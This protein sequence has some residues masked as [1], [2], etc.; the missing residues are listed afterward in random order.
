K[1]LRLATCVQ[2]LEHVQRDAKV[3]VPVLDNRDLRADL[4]V[5][6]KLLADLPAQTLAERLPGVT[7][8]AGE[9]PQAAEHG[10]Q[11]ALR[12]QDMPVPVADH[13]CGHIVVRRARLLRPDRAL[14]LH[15]KRP[16]LA[17]ISDR[18][19]VAARRARHAHP[20]P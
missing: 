17:E 7:L 9:L 10:V 14:L 18:A 13:A 12:D 6:A 15:A 2:A 3:R 4:D 20:L 1:R 16:R 19:D 8:A 11:L 5:D